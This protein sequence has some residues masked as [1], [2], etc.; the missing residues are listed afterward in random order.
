MKKI[1]P[2]E[3]NLIKA[4]RASAKAHKAE[5]CDWSENDYQVAIH[6]D[7][8]PVVSDF[9]EIVSAFAKNANSCTDIELGYCVVYLDEVFYNEEVDEASLELALP[10]GIDVDWETE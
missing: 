10:Y 2:N 6:S 5:F 1:I 9:R 8:V 3:S 7:S 4:L